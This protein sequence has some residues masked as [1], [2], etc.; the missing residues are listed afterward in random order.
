MFFLLDSN[1][2][3]GLLQFEGIAMEFWRQTANKETPRG[4][5]KY[6][7]QVTWLNI[8][9]DVVRPLLFSDVFAFQYRMAVYTLSSHTLVDVSQINEGCTLHVHP[10]VQSTLL[11]R[12]MLQPEELHYRLNRMAR[13]LLRFLPRRDIDIRCHL[14]A[15]Q[16][17]SLVPHVYSVAE[18]AVWIH[19]DETC[20]DLV[21]VACMIAY[22]SQHIDVAVCKQL[23]AFNRCHVVV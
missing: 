16:F 6:C 22:E 23:A 17:I 21:H 5:P 11:E 3:C 20:D 9:E 10:L 12:V 19:D 1:C 14:R 2:K 8:P 15:D 18:K 7:L 13:S 4:I